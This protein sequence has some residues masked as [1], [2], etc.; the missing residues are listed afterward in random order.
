[1]IRSAF[2]YEAPVR[3]KNDLTASYSITSDE[4]N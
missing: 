3:E 2:A 1:M 4:S